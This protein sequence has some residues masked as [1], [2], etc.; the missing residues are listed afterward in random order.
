L[1]KADLHIHTAYSMDCNTPLEQIIAHCVETGINCLAVADHG[2]IDGALKLKEMAPFTIIVA[3]EILTL[4]GEII[5][6]FLTEEVPSKMPAEEAI[7]QIKSQG[8]LVCIPHPYDSL[9]LS[10]FKSQKL[11]VIMP[12]VDI[13][14][15]FNSRSP[16]PNSSAKARQLAQRYSKPASAGS[17]AHTLAEIGSAYV[18]MPDFTGKDNFLGSLAQGKVFGR[19]SSFLVHF[20]STWTKF[21][22][23]SS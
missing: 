7:F 8:G 6:L 5:G 10:A 22:K 15:V 4:S 19:R 12:M 2:T 16:F 18:E 1:I 3:E 9:R 14:E 13:I 21:N 23:R 17:D 20:A 11:N